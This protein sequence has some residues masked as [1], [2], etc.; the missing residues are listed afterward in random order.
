MQAALPSLEILQAI[1]KEKKSKHRTA[2][3]EREVIVV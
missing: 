1:S 2:K 3:S